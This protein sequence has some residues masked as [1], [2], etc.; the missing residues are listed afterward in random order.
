MAIQEE[1]N[2]KIAIINQLWNEIRAEMDRK[3]TVQE[4]NLRHLK[5]IYSHRRQ[6]V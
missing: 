6:Q 4:K 1:T 3:K 5:M 2:N